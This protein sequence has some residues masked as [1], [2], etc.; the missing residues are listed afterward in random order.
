MLQILGVWIDQNWPVKV[1]VVRSRVGER[2]RRGPGHAAAL[3]A[4]GVELGPDVVE[5][6]GEGASWDALAGHA[7]VVLAL[8]ECH[9]LH[10]EDLG[11][12]GQ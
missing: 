6:H 11:D 4:H 7:G 5:V 8:T 1:V 2:E 9:L 3:L 12:A 10:G